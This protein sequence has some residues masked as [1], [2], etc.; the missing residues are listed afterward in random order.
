M[1]GKIGLSVLLMVFT[2]VIVPSHSFAQQNYVKIMNDTESGRMLAIHG[3]RLVSTKEEVT[4]DYTEKNV[5][6]QTYWEHEVKEGA[7]IVHILIENK[8]GKF[9]KYPIKYWGEYS[10]SQIFR[11]LQGEWD[12][13]VW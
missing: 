2:L 1:K 3:K 12:E 13:L 4:V 10:V 6:T 7:T 9:V 11:E 8:P 5:C